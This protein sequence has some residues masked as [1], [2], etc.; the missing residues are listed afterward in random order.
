MSAWRVLRAGLSTAGFAGMKSSPL[1]S[2]SIFAKQ[3]HFATAAR[4]TVL[5]T[6]SQN[7]WQNLH[8]DAQRR[9]FGRQSYQYQRFK[10][11]GGYLRAWAARPTFYYE[12]GGIGA[13]CGGFYIA[14]LET[15][16]VSGRRRFNI[17][18]ATSEEEMGASVYQQTL[19]E[20]GNRLM[21]PSSPEYQMVQRVLRRLI[22]HSGIPDAKWEVHVIKDDRQ[23]NAFVIP[24]GKVFVF[25]GIL[26]V[27]R[28]E[29]G[30]A[31]VLGHEIAHNVAHHAAERTSQ[32][33]IVLPFAIIGSLL[34]GLDIGIGRMLAQLAFTL[35]GSRAQETEADYIGLLMMAES[36]YDPSAA[37][38]LWARME[39]FE[40]SQG[41]SVPQFISTHPSN[42]NRLEKIR[43][44]LP[45]AE[46]KRDASDCGM[47]GYYGEFSA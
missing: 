5:P 39:E 43:S 41:G 14:N 7:A 16:P 21:P 31:A 12:V 11:T 3:F 23:M 29:D 6:R 22:P 25:S 28:G 42:H 10:R 8:R 40:K 13:L 9:A 2:P 18:S 34:V 38:G 44:W 17:V 32:M 19:Q 35:P 46:S 20:F 15:V 24:G 27:C 33:G 4:R 30:L 47:M 37:L 26:K 36:C 45:E 1:H